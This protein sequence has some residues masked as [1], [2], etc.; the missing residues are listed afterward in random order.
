MEEYHIVLDLGKIVHFSFDAL[1]QIRTATGRQP[2]TLL[3]VN[4]YTVTHV[5]RLAISVPPLVAHSFRGSCKGRNVP[6]LIVTPSLLSVNGES[7]GL[8]L[9]NDNRILVL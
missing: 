7:S 9:G 5:R 1:F 6:A 8:P 3:A 4:D 2:E